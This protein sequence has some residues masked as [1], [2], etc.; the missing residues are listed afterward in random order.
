M[1]KVTITAQIDAEDKRRFEEFCKTIGLTSSEL[2]NVYIRKVVRE[3]R[4]PFVIG[5]E[6]PAGEKPSC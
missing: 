2:I 3:Q 6:P 1:S 4:I 5:I